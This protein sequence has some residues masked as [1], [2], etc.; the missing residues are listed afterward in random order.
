MKGTAG[1]GLSVGLI[2]DCRLASLIRSVFAFDVTK[3]EKAPHRLAPA[4]RLS[5][6]FL[7]TSDWLLPVSGRVEQR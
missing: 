1:E 5:V 3:L 6:R 4:G 2:A 7:W